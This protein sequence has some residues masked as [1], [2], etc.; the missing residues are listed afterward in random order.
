MHLCKVTICLGNDFFISVRMYPEA[1]ESFIKD[2][3]EHYN[4]D[5]VATVTDCRDNRCYKIRSSA[6]WYVEKEPL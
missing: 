2:Y 1:Y 6:V 4:D 3:E 5:Y